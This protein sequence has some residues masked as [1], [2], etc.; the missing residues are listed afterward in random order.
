MKAFN[1]R[2]HK[3]IKKYKSYTHLE[4]GYENC[5]YW[6][7]PLKFVKIKMNNKNVES[8]QIDM[9]KVV[10]D[11]WVYD[12]VEKR[13]KRLT[14]NANDITSISFVRFK[15]R[16]RGYWFNEPRK[17]LYIKNYLEINSYGCFMD[18][19]NL[20]QKTEFDGY[21]LKYS[22]IVDEDIV[23]ESYPYNYEEKGIVRI[24]KKYSEIIS[25]LDR[26]VWN[27]IEC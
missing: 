23:I 8:I 22:W 5:E 24:P 6:T 2:K 17:N 9:K 1:K 27:I 3:G 16:T 21:I 10:V 25:K 14:H 4:I 19:D 20:L 18:N 13:I 11:K 12:S 26:E 7:I 15:E